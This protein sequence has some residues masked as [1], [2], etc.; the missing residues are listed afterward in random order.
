MIEEY[1]QISLKENVLFQLPLIIDGYEPE[2]LYLA[3]FLLRL[4]I[5][6]N[7]GDETECFEGMSSEIA[8][9]Y[10]PR[11]PTDFDER[12]LAAGGYDEELERYK[13]CI[14]FLMFPEMKS[15][16]FCPQKDKSPF[17]HRIADLHDL[18]KV[19]ERC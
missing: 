4:V 10:S 11:P 9:F 8:R 14:K 7:W 2:M 12:S 6:V 3:I 17:H 1:Y 15:S 13:W 19:F 16:D 5:N 18:Y